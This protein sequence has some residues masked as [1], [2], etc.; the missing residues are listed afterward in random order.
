MH[1]LALLGR[2]ADTTIS[3]MMAKQ[4]KKL[5][6][7][8]ESCSPAMYSCVLNAFAVAIIRVDL[9]RWTD[10]FTRLCGTATSAAHKGNYGVPTVEF[11]LQSSKYEYMLL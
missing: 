9:G 6:V 11:E 10:A 2:L 8:G 7:D 4:V 3:A 5:V 1:A